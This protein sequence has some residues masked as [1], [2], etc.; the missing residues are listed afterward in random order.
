MYLTGV[1]ADASLKGGPARRVLTGNVLALGLVSL[2]TD[3]SAEMVSSVL[4]AYLVLGLHLSVAQYGA[5]D[6]LYTGATALTRL[7]G[8][9]AADRF[10]QRKAVA[11][12]GYGLSAL[13]KFGL[14][15]TGSAPAAIGAVLAADRTGKGLRTAPRDALITLS[16]PEERLGRAFGAHRALDSLGAFA[17]PIVALGVLA[18]AGGAGRSYDAVFV[19]S[20]CFA[21]LGI[22]LLA[23][24]VRDRRDPLPPEAV[25]PRAALRLLGR[26]RFRAVCAAAALLGTATIGDGFVYL[27]LQRR[28]DLPVTAFPLLAVGTALA[29]LLLAPPL[30]RL[31]DR[32]G[33]RP[34]AL[35]GYAALLAV[36]LLL[37][38][39]HGSPWCVLLLYGAFY[40]ATDGVLMA[41]AG[42]LLP[43][44][45]RTSGLA[46]VQ[47]GQAMAYLLSSALFGLAWQS[48]GTA[49]ACLAAAGAAAV[50]LAASIPLLE[51]SKDVR[52]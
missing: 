23:L 30:G 49:P 6:G 41:I 36:Y 43:P 18:L 10:R 24:F 3:V 28:D 17:G 2:V 45:L 29:Y 22:V 25:S 38:T 47:T 11:A 33:R 34:V 16:V 42:P 4:P 52:K 7:V 8:G 21:L 46:L 26:G 39:G 13:A 37:A 50:A 20:A 32:V 19:A 5:V 35:G 31:A 51:R 9:Y 40:A 1:R 14:L 44:E 48:W 12:V 15:C 27:V